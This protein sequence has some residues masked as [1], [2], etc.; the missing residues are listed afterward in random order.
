MAFGAYAGWAYL[1]YF[2]SHGDER[3]KGDASED[4]A[5]AAQFPSPLQPLVRRL[6]DPCHA[7]FCGQPARGAGSDGRD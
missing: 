5:F 7:L 4:F 2:Q 3:P 6:T 1:R